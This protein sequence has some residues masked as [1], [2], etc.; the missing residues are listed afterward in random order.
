MMTQEKR[1]DN[2]RDV[3]KHSEYSLS[4]ITHLNSLQCFPLHP[5]LY[6][7]KKIRSC[8]KVS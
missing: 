8:L 5:I 7:V 4:F 6:K 1:G 2:D 3:V